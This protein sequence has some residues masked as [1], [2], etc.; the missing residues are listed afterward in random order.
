MV[1][2]D[3]RSFL[4]LPPPYDQRDLEPKIRE[5]PQATREKY[6]TD[7][8]GVSAVKFPRPKSEEEKRALV[9]SFLSGLRKLFDRR[10]NWTFMQPLFLTMENCA[11]CQTCSSACPVYVESGKLD[12]YRPTYRS[13]IMRRLYKKYVKAGG[14]LT[15]RISGNDI[16]L[17]WTMIARLMELCYRCTICRRCAQTCPIGAD[18]G[19]VTRELRKIFSQEMGINVDALAFQGLDASAEDRLEHRDVARALSRQRRV[20]W[21][22]TPKNEPA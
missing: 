11:R 7:L 18:N 1:E 6:E 19:L 22:R 3:T 8:D 4:P 20:S 21:S 2:L 12:I 15:A 10:E 16:D 14:Q 13:D 5:L 9:A 17:T